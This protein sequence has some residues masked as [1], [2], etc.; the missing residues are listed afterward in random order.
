M[1]EMPP[2][3]QVELLRVLQ[4]KRVRPVGGETDEAIDVRVVAASNRALEDL[5][6][7]GRFRQDL[8]YRLA[9]VTL[10]IPPLRA[11]ADD[12]PALA[13]FFLTRIAEDHGSPRKRLTRE[14]L[15]KLVR[16]AWPGNV[17]Q[18]KHVLESAVVLA[19]GDVIDAAALAVDGSRGDTIPPPPM[20]A[21][22]EVS[23]RVS[24]SARSSSPAK[25]RKAAERQ[26]ILDALEHV[27]WN[28]VKAATVL[29]MPLMMLY[30]RLREYG[31]LD[32]EEN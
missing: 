26:R 22:G 14:A 15:S 18:L 27:N 16:A 7:E 28:K 8:Y 10:R 31:L 11:R 2:K 29:G 20:N 24:E 32:E 5:V 4:E 23:P 17:R 6:R 30:R 3:M 12:I 19:D 21:A 1:A 13:S 9:V 25:V